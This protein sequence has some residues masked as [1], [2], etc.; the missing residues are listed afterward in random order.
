MLDRRVNVEYRKT[1][2]LIPYA[3]NSRTH[4][5]AQIKQVAA[6]MQEFGFTNPV[7]IDEKSTIIAGHC[8]VMAAEKLGIDDVPT[9]TLTGLSDA[10]RRAYVIVD[11]SLAENAG[12]NDELL[13]AEIETLLD[14][15]YDIGVLGLA[16]DR[17]DELLDDG[18]AG[19]DADADDIGDVWGVIVNVGNEQE[20][21]D[22]LNR[23][24]S[25]G[26]KV[27]ALL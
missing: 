6:S 9:I 23:L 21:V 1:G 8:R 7:L 5:P 2:D 3:R 18:E 17:L 15:K 10:Q 12:W 25:E 14:D 13:A 19:S 11:N 4:T 24:Q 27:K 26:Y 22:L 16:D 20:Q